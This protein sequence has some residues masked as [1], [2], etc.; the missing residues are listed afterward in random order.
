MRG[1]ELSTLLGAAPPRVT[2]RAFV[3]LLG[4]AAVW[5]LPA[6]AQQSALPVIGFLG[7]TAPDTVADRLRAFRQGLKEIGYL[8]GE[9]V[10][11]AYRWT[12][13]PGRLPELAVEFVRQRVA[14][15]V[16]VAGATLAAKA[17]T[18][19]IP[20][21]FIATEDPV[22]LGL[23]ASL[24]RPGGNL[25]GVNM[26]SAEVVA[27][28]LELLRELVPA[29]T[30]VALLVNPAG[31]TAETT[32]GDI[33]TAARAMGLNVQ[34][35]NA[36]TS[37]EIDAAFA[38]VARARSEALFVGGDP[39]FSSRR[40]QLANLAARHLVP[41]TTAT[42]EIA[43]VGGLMSY[44]TNIADAWRQV[45]VYVGRILKGVRP[46]DLP[47]MQSSKF[48]LVINAQTARMLGLEV[49][50]S[51]LARADEVIE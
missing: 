2:R 5:P 6:L 34:V 36:S 7:V 38:T 37:R 10:A 3:T 43:D 33:E 35:L 4:G 41:M 44:G 17:A 14:V 8:D 29:S 16:T 30:R 12:E 39:F 21:V 13:E 24:A 9:N 28:R 49:P 20:I 45:G 51:L 46:A 22:R 25:T 31:P 11:T 19:T 48:E 47:V 27:K 23:V 32:V 42:R 40:V 15:I 26:F 50:P 18:T 1:P